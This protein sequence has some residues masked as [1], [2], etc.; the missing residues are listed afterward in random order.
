VTEI[1]LKGDLIR[2]K[3]IGERVANGEHERLYTADELLDLTED[4][5]KLNV[6]LR[7]NAIRAFRAQT[8]QE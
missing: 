5:D 4:H 1:E 7:R 3:D 2:V 8:L 6:V